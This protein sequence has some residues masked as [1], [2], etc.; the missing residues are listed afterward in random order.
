MLNL[1]FQILSYVFNCYIYF[2]QW[3]FD[4]PNPPKHSYIYSFRALIFLILYYFCTDSLKKKYNYIAWSPSK[5]ILCAQGKAD[6]KRP[7]LKICLSALVFISPLKQVD[8]ENQPPPLIP[9]NEGK[10]KR[11]VFSKHAK[12]I[13]PIL[14]DSQEGLLQLLLVLQSSN[15]YR[16]RCR[17][18]NH[19]NP[20]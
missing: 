13:W 10:C 19:R 17:H 9:W 11:S 1:I 7:P 2:W 15:L 4:C 12:T 14:H 8:W 3:S 6:W 20:N 5:K 18:Y 16:R